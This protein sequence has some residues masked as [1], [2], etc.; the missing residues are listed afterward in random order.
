MSQTA[1]LAADDGNSATVLERPLATDSFIDGADSSTAKE[2]Q[3]RSSQIW[4]QSTSPTFQAR[5]V[6]PSSP[7]SPIFSR[8]LS[9]AHI[10]N[11]HFV[12][13]ESANFHHKPAGSSE[14]G[15]TLP[16]SVNVR[17][18]PQDVVDDSVQPL[19]AWFSSFV[20]MGPSVASATPDDEPPMT[21]AD[22]GFYKLQEKLYLHHWRTHLLGTLPTQFAEVENLVDRC[23]ALRP[24][25]IALSACDLARAR[26]DVRRCTIGHETQWLLSPNREHQQY[27]KRYYNLALHELARMDYS[28]Q[29]STSLLATLMLFAHIESYVGSFRGAAFHHHGI[30]H[31]LSARHGFCGQSVLAGDLVSIWVSLRAQN[32]RFRIPFT[33]PDFQ[34]SL[35]DLGLDPEQVLNPSAAR[36][37]TVMVNMLQSW[38]LSLM[39]LFERYTGR[40]DMESISSRCCRD[41]YARLPPPGVTQPWRPKE[42]IPD[43]D[44]EALLAEQR[45]GLDRWYAALPPSHLALESLALKSSAQDPLQ[46]GQPPLQ[47]NTHQAAM[48]YIYYVAARIFQSKEGIDEFLAPSPLSLHHSAQPDHPGVDH[49]LRLLLRII[50]GLDIMACARHSSYSVGI[51]EILHMCHLR[52]PRCSQIIRSG[53][54]YIIAGYVNNCITHEGSGLVL[55]FQHVFEEIEE[56]R[57]LGRDLFYIIPRFS[58]DT[59]RQLIYDDTK[60]NV[61]YG[62]DKTTGKFFCQ[63]IPPRS[64]V[65]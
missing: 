47:F 65:P 30:E 44:Y 46:L 19:V 54:H 16:S 38:R 43:E 12:N 20:D 60:P 37:E 27:G 48:N 33:V 17:D 58:P 7:R 64:K 55:S 61:V 32:W 23:L 26:M 52:L 3:R 8:G 63:F 11:G 62:R 41:Y 45:M 1:S 35:A 56:Q 5:R 40:G 14:S 10:E 50:G 4:A 21:E 13:P 51:L 59:Q 49:W 9:A 6:D 36:D 29:E 28:K 25:I 2:H 34:R 18:P 31:L 42:P 53:V 39:I 57:G 22:E 24:A 15:E